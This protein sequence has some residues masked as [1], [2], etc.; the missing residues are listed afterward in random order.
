M[1]ELKIC[2][3]QAKKPNGDSDGSLNAPKMYRVQSQNKNFVPWCCQWLFSNARHKTN[4][5]ALRT[6]SH[7]GQ[8]SWVWLSREYYCAPFLNH[9]Q[10]LQLQVIFIFKEAIAGKKIKIA[11]KMM[12]KNCEAAVQPLNKKATWDASFH[13]QPCYVPLS[14]S[15][16]GGRQWDC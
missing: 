15:V 5:A 6:I 12:E 2:S 14:L 10:Q 11:E 1:K 4:L 7:K 16:S 9:C 3:P 8:V 13:K